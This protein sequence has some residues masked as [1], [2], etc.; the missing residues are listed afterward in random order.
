MTVALHTKP[1]T[2]RRRLMDAR[3][4][5]IRSGRLPG[6][7]IADRV[8]LRKAITFCPSCLPKFNAE[9]AEYVTKRNLPIVRGRCDGCMQYT[10]H[11]RLLVHYSL[12]STL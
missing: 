2:G 11:G 9:R 8:D 6:G 5:G 10:G 7:H 4:P 3:S 1:W 12:A